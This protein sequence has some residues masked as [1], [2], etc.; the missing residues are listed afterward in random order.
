MSIQK[1]SSK[2]KKMKVLLKDK[3]IA[4]FHPETR[5]YSLTALE[6]MCEIYRTVYVK[7]EQGT[8]GKGIMRIEHT[9]AATANTDE[10]SSEDVTK[11]PYKLH[12]VKNK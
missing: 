10:S 12:Y 1:V 3:Y 7:P 2:W 5:K 4:P 8:H 6:Q 11:A 9:S